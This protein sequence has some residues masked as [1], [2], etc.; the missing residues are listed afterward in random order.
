MTPNGLA[1]GSLSRPA[2]DQPAAV[3]LEPHAR[4]ARRPH[5]AEQVDDLEGRFRIAE[6]FGP[7]VGNAVA[8][9]VGRRGVWPKCQV[10][11]HAVGGREPRTLADQDRRAFGAERRRNGVAD[12]DPPVADDDQRRDPP[13]L[14]A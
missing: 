9:R 14:R 2:L 10:R 12:R 5:G 8:V 3:V 4:E 11:A 6:S 13:V 1:R 7:D